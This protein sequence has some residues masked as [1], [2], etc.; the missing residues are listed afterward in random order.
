MFYR[1]N[2]QFKTTYRDDQQIFGITQDR[3]FVLAIVAFA[4]LGVPA[5]ADEYLFRAIFIP[6]LIMALA[7]LGVNVLVG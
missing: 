4:F 1:E 5:L 3:Y 7:A 6:F 2:G